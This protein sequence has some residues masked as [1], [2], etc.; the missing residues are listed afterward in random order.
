M[1]AVLLSAIVVQLLRIDEAKSIVR[2]KGREGKC[3]LAQANLHIFF[4][5]QSSTGKRRELLVVNVFSL[6]E[7]SEMVAVES[8]ILNIGNCMFNRILSMIQ[9]L[10]NGNH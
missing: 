9:Q 2:I 5:L 6:I 4:C 8:F 1:Y 10:Y 3:L 7:C